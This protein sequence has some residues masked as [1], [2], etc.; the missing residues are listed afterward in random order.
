MLYRNL[1]LWYLAVPYRFL[2][3]MT[4]VRLSSTGRVSIDAM[5]GEAAQNPAT[6]SKV[7]YLALPV[8]YNV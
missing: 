3:S 8:K 4:L 6:P 2:V 1:R 7:A 5:T